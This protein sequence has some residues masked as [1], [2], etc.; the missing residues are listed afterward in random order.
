MK[1]ILFILAVCLC[2]VS[3]KKSNE[4]ITEIDNNTIMTEMANGIIRDLKYS[5]NEPSSL[6][7]KYITSFY[8]L[9]NKD[10]ADRLTTHYGVCK[11]YKKWLEEGYEHITEKDTI[12]N[13]LLRDAENVRYFYVQVEFYGKNSFGAYSGSE[14]AYYIVEVEEIY[15]NYDGTHAYFVWI[16]DAD[17]IEFL[18]LYK[19]DKSF[20]Y[21][22][23]LSA[24]TLSDL[25]P[26]EYKF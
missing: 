7:I 14:E 18:Q 23:S 21:D 4:K 10:I 20:M 25:I 13:S 12:Y 2:F 9:K 19:K 1:K 22:T 24:S 6:K 8:E 15:T 5:L 17:L 26:I 11:I 16:H 3:C